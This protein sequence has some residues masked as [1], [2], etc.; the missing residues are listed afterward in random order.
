VQRLLPFAVVL[1]FGVAIGWSITN[2]SDRDD[3]PA[4]PAKSAPD[5]YQILVT[6][7]GDSAPDRQTF[8]TLRPFESAPV[9][10]DRQPPGTWVITIQRGAP[11]SPTMHTYTARTETVSGS[12]PPG[13]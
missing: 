7:P 12:E 1:L 6:R 2:R 11:S 13:G 5:V 3:R 8:Y 4:A 10:V 9:T